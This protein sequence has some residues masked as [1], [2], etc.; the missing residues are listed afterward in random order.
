MLLMCTKTSNMN[1]EIIK[2]EEA[3]K[4]FIEW[5]P[6]LEPNEKFYLCLFARRKY[7]PE[8]MK[9]NHRAQVKRFL[10]DKKRLFNKIKQL[11]V[12]EGAYTTKGGAIPGKALA[13]YISP[14][15]RNL[16]NASY[17]AI[18]NLTKL[19]R[20]GN[21]GFNPHS[22]VMSTIQKT[23]SR[24]VF[25]DFDFD[26]KDDPK[27]DKGE[28]IHNLQSYLGDAGQVIETRGGLHCLVRPDRI[29]KEQ[30]KHWYQTVKTFGGESIDQSG[31]LLLPVVGCCQGGFI[32]RFV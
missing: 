4:E 24:T 29:P 21:E 23:K 1:Y 27:I 31:D 18:I 5:L 19:L 3:L 15:P 8:E 25:V 7:A 30:R 28:L 12:P 26:V 20:N 10:S 2:N 11:E 17:Q 22:E 9:T 6:E 16:K 13:L 14:N 32:P